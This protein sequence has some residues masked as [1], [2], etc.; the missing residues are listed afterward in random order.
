MNQYSQL[1]QSLKRLYESKQLKE[2]MIVS[3][4]TKKSITEKERDYILGVN[5]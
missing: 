1:V 5:K 2:S 4:Y 3:L